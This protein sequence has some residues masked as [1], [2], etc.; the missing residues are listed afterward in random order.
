MKYLD[1]RE[2]ST[3]N[4]GGPIVDVWEDIKNICMDVIPDFIR[5]FMDGW[6][7]N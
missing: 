1:S 5:G 2:L 4:G 7:N 3:I 6:N